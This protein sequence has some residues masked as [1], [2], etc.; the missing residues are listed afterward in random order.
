MDKAKDLMTPNPTCL[1]LGDTVRQALR[2]I[3][4]LN[5]H[6]LPVLSPSGQPV[7]ILTEQS[8]VKA[9]VLAHGSGSLDVEIKSVASI[10]D[11]VSLVTENESFIKLTHKLIAAQVN[12]LLVVD[13]DEKLIGIIS[14]RDLLNR[15]GMRET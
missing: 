4:Q 1:K 9:I 2:L 12:R 3:L 5:V 6:S 10:L 15:F 7:G 11:P 13:K 8:L 14:P